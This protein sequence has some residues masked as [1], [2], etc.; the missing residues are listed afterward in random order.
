MIVTVT[1]VF[2]SIAWVVKLGTVVDASLAL[3]SS[4]WIVY[5]NGTCAPTTSSVKSKVA[6][7]SE[8]FLTTNWK[9]PFVPG[10]ILFAATSVSGSPSVSKIVSNKLNAI[11]LVDDKSTSDNVPSLVPY[12]KAHL[13]TLALSLPVTVDVYL[14]NVP[15]TKVSDTTKTKV[16]T[17]PN[18]KILFFFHFFLP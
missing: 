4:T 6:L 15:D 12:W 13:A 7:T 17:N 10:A 16:I 1:E 11:V 5:S 9:L 3:P 18:V 14:A 8:V 2:I